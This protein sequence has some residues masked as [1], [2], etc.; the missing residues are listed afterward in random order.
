VCIS[1][2]RKVQRHLLA[3]ITRGYIMF[4][5]QTCGG[6]PPVTPEILGGGNNLKF[7]CSL[8]ISDR[9]TRS[10]IRKVFLGLLCGCG[11]Q[12]DKGLETRHVC[13]FIVRGWQLS[14]ISTSPAAN[15]CAKTHNT[16]ALSETG[17]FM[18]LSPFAESTCLRRFP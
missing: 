8:K 1:G 6:T 5:Q 2:S 7:G 18:K 9:Q 17:L 14:C 10:E 12:F 16:L 13:A 15:V 4:C 11:C 3:N